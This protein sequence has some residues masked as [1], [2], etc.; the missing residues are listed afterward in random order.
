[1]IRSF[2]ILSF[3]YAL[4]IV[5]KNDFKPKDNKVKAV[6]PAI[7]Y[8]H[9]Q[10]TAPL[11]FLTGTGNSPIITVPRLRELMKWA[12]KTW[13]RLEAATNE[14]LDSLIFNSPKISQDPYPGCDTVE[15]IQHNGI[16]NFISHRSTPAV[17]KDCSPNSSNKI[18]C[19]QPGNK[20]TYSDKIVQGLI[21]LDITD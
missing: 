9:Q 21:E 6:S 2:L 20:E 8:D 13:Y 10:N 5:Q 1:M 14:G 15:D 17:Q 4:A 18:S 16:M 19:Q 12:C 3:F 11:F 7:G